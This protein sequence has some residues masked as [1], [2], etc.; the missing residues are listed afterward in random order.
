M[1]HRHPGDPGRYLLAR[2]VAPELLAALP[3]G[4]V[5]PV[6]CGE[7]DARNAGDQPY[8]PGTQR[9]WEYWPQRAGC[10]DMLG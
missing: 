7:I 3:L 4:E 1:S 10:G 8:S 2:S 6:P 9:A 5:K